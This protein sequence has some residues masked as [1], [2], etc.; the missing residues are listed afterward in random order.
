ML[1]FIKKFITVITVK[2]TLR[3]YRST[4]KFTAIPSRRIGYYL[5]AWKASIIVR[6]GKVWLSWMPAS[7]IQYHIV[8]FRLFVYLRWKQREDSLWEET[9]KG[10]GGEISCA[11][12]PQIFF[13]LGAPSFGTFYLQCIPR[14]QTEW[15]SSDIILVFSHDLPRSAQSPTM[16]SEVQ[17]KLLPKSYLPYYMNFTSQQLCMI[18]TKTQF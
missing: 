1:Y 10:L 7:Q 17:N 15:L 12:S 18:L 14:H 11:E 6:K 9:C 16:V 4:M 8:F 3:Q 2:V 13:L 5:T